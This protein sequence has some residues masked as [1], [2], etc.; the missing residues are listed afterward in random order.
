MFAID[1]SKYGNCKTQQKCVSGVVT[2][3]MSVENDPSLFAI[4]ST[5]GEQKFYIYKNFVLF[6]QFARGCKI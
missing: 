4:H 2:H 1:F 5:C 3:T 6:F